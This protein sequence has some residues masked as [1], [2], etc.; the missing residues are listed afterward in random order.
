MRNYLLLFFFFFSFTKYF[1]LYK[2]RKRNQHLEANK[3]TKPPL[4]SI[5]GIRDL[6]HYLEL[7]IL[8]SI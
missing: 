7:G 6:Y 5:T 4:F 3:W 2:L 8:A 1:N